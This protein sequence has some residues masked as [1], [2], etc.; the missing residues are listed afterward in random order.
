MEQESAP[1]S[2]VRDLFMPFLGTSFA[3]PRLIT[4]PLCVRVCMCTHGV[5]LRHVSQ[6][7]HQLFPCKGLVPTSAAAA[8]FAVQYLVCV[9]ALQFLTLSPPPIFKVCV[10]AILEHIQI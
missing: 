5:T 10:Q 6:Q 7:P 2:P 3:D 4:E 9:V 8:K 1:M